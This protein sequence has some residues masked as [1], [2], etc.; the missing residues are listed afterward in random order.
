MLV[1]SAVVRPEPEQQALHLPTVARL[2][3]EQ[4]VQ[5]PPQYLTKL[6]H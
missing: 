3:L 1:N 4:Q 6:K 2:I 5:V